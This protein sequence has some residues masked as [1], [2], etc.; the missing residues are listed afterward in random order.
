MPYI[1]T[2]VRVLLDK[3]LDALSYQLNTMPLG[4][5][6][7]VLTVLVYRY[8][9]NTS[10]GKT[11]D[12]E[13]RSNVMHTLDDAKNAIYETEMKPYEENKRMEN[14]DVY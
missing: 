5:L 2:E 14:G 8:M 10:L 7:Y 9:H 11:A 13:R 6:T 1:D 4:S 12:Y 3:R